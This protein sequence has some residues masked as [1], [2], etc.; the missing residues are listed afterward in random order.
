MSDETL[1]A[2]NNQTIKKSSGYVFLTILQGLERAY[3]DN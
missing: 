1:D 3:C 2:I